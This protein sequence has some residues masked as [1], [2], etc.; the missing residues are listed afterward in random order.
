MAGKLKINQLQLG[1]SA[2]ATQNFVLQ[3]N[4]DGTAKLARGNAGATTQDIMTVDASGKVA[5]PQN[6]VVQGVKAWCNF[7]GT[8]TGTNAPRAGSN[9]SSVTRNGA[10]DYTINFTSALAD[11]NYVASFSCPNRTD[12]TVAVVMEYSTDGVNPATK[13]TTSFRIAVRAASN[14]TGMDTA[15]INV[16]IFGN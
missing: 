2:T 15:D 10:G 9:V 13:T 16:T 7:N 1:D 6:T 3:S 12:T 11:A 8:L 5:F 14:N 4:V